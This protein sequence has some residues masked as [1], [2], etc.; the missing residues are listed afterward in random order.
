M[1][2]GFCAVD[3]GKVFVVED[4]DTAFNIIA[5]DQIP[6]LFYEK[7]YRY[8]CASMNWGASK[9]IDSFADVCVALNKTTMVLLSRDKLHEMNPQTKNKFYVACTRAHENL[10]LMDCK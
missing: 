1:Q 7:F 10:Y 9:G 5:N 2:G 3:Y 6:K 8:A 4:E